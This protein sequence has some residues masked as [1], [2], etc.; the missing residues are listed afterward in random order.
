MGCFITYYYRIGSIDIE[1]HHQRYR[2]PLRTFEFCL[3]FLISNGTAGEGDLIAVQ[4]ECFLVKCRISRVVP[5][6]G[7]VLLFS[8]GGQEMQPPIYLNKQYFTSSYFENFR[9][10]GAASHTTRRSGVLPLSGFRQLSSF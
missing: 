4:H 10:V 6:L 8:P 2:A 3:I 9:A 7:E 1:L 5:Q